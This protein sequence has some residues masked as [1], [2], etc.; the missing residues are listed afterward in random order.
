MAFVG[1]KFYFNGKPIKKHVLDK[2]IKWEK[3]LSA[4]KNGTDDACFLKERLG[5]WARDSIQYLKK[6]GVIVASS[7]T[8]VATYKVSEKGEQLIKDVKQYQKE[9]KDEESRMF[10]DC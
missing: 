7:N 10:R 8:R 4:I 6:E 1:E 3:V 9:K 2:Y 5:A